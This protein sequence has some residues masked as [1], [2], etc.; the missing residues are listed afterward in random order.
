[1][2]KTG[3]S[4][5]LAGLLLAG[6]VSVAGAGEMMPVPGSAGD[7]GAAVA[8][9][10]GLFSG[11]MNGNETARE[12][13][14]TIRDRMA[15]QREQGLKTAQERQRQALGQADGWQL[16][17]SRGSGPPWAGHTPGGPSPAP[18]PVSAGGA[19]EFHKPTT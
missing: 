16:S 5:V 15:V 14:A 8:A 18:V 9:G 12:T 13:A 19:A 1:M 2:K 3:K 4:F 7:Q 17:E 10:Q 11:R 6:I